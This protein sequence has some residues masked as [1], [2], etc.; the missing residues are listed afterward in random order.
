MPIIIV[1]ATGYYMDGNDCKMCIGDT[2][3]RE[4]G[5]LT[6]CETTCNETVTPNENHTE[7]GE[8][9]ILKLIYLDLLHFYI[10]DKF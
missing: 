2:I 7:C 9:L 8:S 5:N 6:H 3:K 10:E 1:C 4:V